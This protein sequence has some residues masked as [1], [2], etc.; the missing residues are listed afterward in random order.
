MSFS[1]HL[2]HLKKNIF[3]SAPS[4]FI[5]W[6]VSG[7]RLCLQL[8][9][10]TGVRTAFDGG[11]R[12]WS[13]MLTGSLVAFNDDSSPISASV[14]SPNEDLITGTDCS[15][16]RSSQIDLDSYVPR[17][18]FYVDEDACEFFSLRSVPIG[19]KSHRCRLNSQPW[20]MGHYRRLLGSAVR[21]CAASSAD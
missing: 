1:Y 2:G 17:M 19:R 13:G 18:A 16:E 3:T 20:A 14:A 6:L 8:V 9:Q 7:R 12:L 10:V 5:R 21:A 11:G 15:M 4:L